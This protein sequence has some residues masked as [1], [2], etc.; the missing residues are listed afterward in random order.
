MKTN[1]HS[2]ERQIMADNDFETIRRAQAGDEAAFSGLIEIHAR[3]VHRLAVRFC[4]NAPDAE[5][6]SQEVWIKVHKSIGTFRGDSQF[7]T[8]VRQILIRTFLSHRPRAET[9][10][11]DEFVFAENSFAEN[12]DRKILADKVRDALS[13]LTA[14]QRLMFLLKHEEGMTYEEIAHEFECSSGTVKKSIFRTVHKLRQRFGVNLTH[15]IL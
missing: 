3:R 7:Y 10:C 2:R 1:E 12:I 15:S 8:W 13:E 11:F 6:L 4:R 5:D 14:Q 9:V